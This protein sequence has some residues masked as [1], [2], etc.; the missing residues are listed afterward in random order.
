MTYRFLAPAE[1]DF[2]EATDYYD[3]AVPGLGLEFL[4]EVERTIARILRH[5]QAW[6]KI[7]EH[8]RKCRTRRF[9]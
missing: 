7:S 5:P 1:C 8:Q 6:T 2:A 4:K 3:R 9:P